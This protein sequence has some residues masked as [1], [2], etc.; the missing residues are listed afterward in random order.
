MQTIVI[1]ENQYDRLILN[2][3]NTVISTKIIVT[4]NQYKR[5]FLNEATCVGAD[6]NKPVDYTTG[7]ATENG[8]YVNLEEGVVSQGYFQAGGDVVHISYF[9]GNYMKGGL[10]N[11]K[12]SFGLANLTY[13][14]KQTG[15]FP[16]KSMEKFVKNIWRAGGGS[17]KVKGGVKGSMVDGAKI[18]QLGISRYKEAL[19]SGKIKM[20]F[21]QY[22]GL[23]REIKP[24]VLG[25]DNLIVKRK[26]KALGSLHRAAGHYPLNGTCP[27]IVSETFSNVIFGGVYKF[28]EWLNT[29]N[30]QDWI[31][32]TAGACL[33]ISAIFPPAALIAMPLMIA[34]EAVNLGISV[35][36][37][38][39]E[40]GSYADV[41]LRLACLVA[42][43]II[44]RSIKPL[45]K[46]GKK[47]FQESFAYALEFGKKVAQKSVK[48]GVPHALKWLNGLNLDNAT[49]KG[50]KEW[51][52]VIGKNPDE[53]QRASKNAEALVEGAKKG[54]KMEIK[55]VADS[56][57]KVRKYFSG[58]KGGV[59]KSQYIDDIL[60]LPT[61]LVGII[62]GVVLG[63]AYGLNFY[64][65][66]KEEGFNDQQIKKI[67]DGMD[68]ELEK[69]EKYDVVKRGYAEGFT[70]DILDE[71]SEKE[72]N[73]L[74]K[75]YDKLIDNWYK[76]YNKIK[77]D[78]ENIISQRSYLY[79]Q[80]ASYCENFHTE[81]ETLSLVTITHDQTDEEKEVGQKRAAKGKKIDVDGV[82]Y[83]MIIQGDGVGLYRLNKEKRWINIIAEEKNC[84]LGSKVV[85][86][87]CKNNAT[88]NKT[89]QVFCTKVYFEM[90]ISEE[91]LLDELSRLWDM[92][93]TT[94]SVEDIKA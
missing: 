47:V 27:T 17:T 92:Y 54:N 83:S 80:I 94:V 64:N 58:G 23:G 34:L 28:F 66:L 29:L 3:I 74:L 44:G 45:F 62:I 24:K 20:S 13:F 84:K 75:K 12:D 26:I 65:W 38:A 60:E 49:L 33:I 39:T 36:N 42:G 71:L 10:I 69:F 87:F 79:D 6:C 40:K 85:N 72:K 70:P 56:L 22:D 25:S 21:K 41:G 37:L 32:V 48:E 86:E 19:T 35:Y 15:V 14:G 91:D 93:T 50:V 43:P 9:C 63:S 57:N 61:P 5:L 73:I 4:E 77:A 90:E 18:I 16:S 59:L 88:K 7:W 1:T 81:G 82:E 30:A 46:L 2:S 89:N 31:D 8:E 67:S 78:I 11:E 68:N 55:T 53:F 76:N 51:L 52:E